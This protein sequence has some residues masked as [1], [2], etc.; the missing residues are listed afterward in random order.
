[1]AG[2]PETNDYSI[3]GMIAP[4]LDEASET[5]D[6]LI[7]YCMTRWRLGQMEFD[8]IRA[9][10]SDAILGQLEKRAQDGNRQIFATSLHLCANVLG[11]EAAA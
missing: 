11:H 2:Q 1:M 4:T 5:L 6:R 7:D 3:D 10:G 8:A 9:Y